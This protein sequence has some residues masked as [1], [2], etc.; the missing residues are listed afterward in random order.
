MKNAPAGAFLLLTS[1]FE[2]VYLCA[3]G[4]KDNKSEKVSTFIF[5]RGAGTTNT[6]G[7]HYFQCKNDEY[8]NVYDKCVEW[9]EAAHTYFTHAGAIDK[10][11]RNC[12]GTLSLEQK[13][14]TKNPWFIRLATTLLGMH[15]LDAYR[16][17]KFNLDS[18]IQPMLVLEFTEVVAAQHIFDDSSDMSPEEHDLDTATPSSSQKVQNEKKHQ[19]NV[20]ILPLFQIHY[21]NRKDY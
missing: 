16:L 21:V 4:Y 18:R 7:S 3:L 17:Y 8:G 19:K 5:T 13:W 15:L 20:W 2:G 11:N 10:H 1:K 9:P 6:K 14:L 12:Q